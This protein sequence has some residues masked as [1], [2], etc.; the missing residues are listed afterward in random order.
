MTGFRNNGDW[1]DLKLNTTEITTGQDSFGQFKDIGILWSDSKNAGY[2]FGTVVRQYPSNPDL[3]LFIQLYPNGAMKS[4]AGS[5]DKVIS[6]FPSFL[7]DNDDLGFNQWGGSM[8][9]DSEGI[10]KLDGSTKPEAG[11]NNG[12]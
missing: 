7:L 6:S 2:D 12:G 3:I 8:A 9:G 4:S 1:A 11:L 10:G 5:S